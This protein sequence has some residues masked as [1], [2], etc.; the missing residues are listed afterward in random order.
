[1]AK[2]LLLYSSVNGHTQKI[3][4]KLQEVIEQQGHQVSVVS[5]SEAAIPDLSSFDKIVIGSSIHY[6][7]H[8]PLILDFI[9]R[10]KA[11][12]DSK[13]N[14][15]FSV[16]IVARKPEK[17]TPATNP[18]FRKFLKRSP[19][20]PKQ[21][22]VFAGKLDYPSYGPFDRFMIRL[23]MWITKGP[24]DPSSVIEFTNW[25][26]VERFGQQVADVIETA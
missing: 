24:T 13:P 15:F 18:Y 14:A 6:G 10:H 3:S 9:K 11:E 20:Q 23:I 16:N 22:A 17:N 2:F 19:W 5:I 21:T 25:A 7:K 1:M 12:L 4:Y 26:E 8:H